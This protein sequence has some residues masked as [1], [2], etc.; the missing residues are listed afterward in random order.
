[1]PREMPPEAQRAGGNSRPRAKRPRHTTRG[2]R[3]WNYANGAAGALQGD[4]GEGRAFRINKRK[5]VVGAMR[6]P[7]RF[8]AFK[9][10]QAARGARSAG[11]SGETC[12]AMWNSWSRWRAGNGASA[13]DDVK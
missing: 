1:M 13:G 5:G 9:R 11:R 3:A 10:G 4:S 12:L 8:M 6:T 2:L 7:R